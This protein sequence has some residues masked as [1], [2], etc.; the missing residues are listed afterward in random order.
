MSGLLPTYNENMGS[1]RVHYYV[2]DTGAWQN[3][4]AG[5]GLCANDPVGSAEVSWHAGDGLPESL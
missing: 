4:K 1:V 2:D 5:T 3:L